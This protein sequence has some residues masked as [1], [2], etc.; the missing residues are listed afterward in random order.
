MSSIIPYHNSF[1]KITHYFTIMLVL[2]SNNSTKMSRGFQIFV[3]GFCKIISGHPF[4]RVVL[5]ITDMLRLI[6]VL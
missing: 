4:S 3:G 5:M 1:M 6:D 2:L